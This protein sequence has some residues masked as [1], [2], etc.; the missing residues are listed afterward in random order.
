M[1]KLLG[2]GSGLLISCSV[3][4]DFPPVLP[5]TPLGHIVQCRDTLGRDRG[6]LGT[7]TSTSEPASDQAFCPWPRGGAGEKPT[8]QV[9]TFACLT[10]PCFQN[11]G[12]PE[13]APCQSGEQLPSLCASPCRRRPPPASVR[14]E[15][16][17]ITNPKKLQSEL[18]LGKFQSILAINIPL[19][20][21]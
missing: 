12:G 10:L 9:A 8:A 19:Q 17:K 20:D 3:V 6:F 18:Y 21:A 5:S 7:G 11:R 2:R 16:V 14:S 1:E 15:S 13:K 4:P